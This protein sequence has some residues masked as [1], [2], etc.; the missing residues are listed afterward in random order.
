MIALTILVC[1]CMLDTTVATWTDPF[2][3]VTEPWVLD[4]PSVAGVTVSRT[5]GVLNMQRNSALDMTMDTLRHYAPAV[6]IKST[7]THTHTAGVTCLRVL[8][9]C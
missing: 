1:V 2:T 4:A 6:Y 3:S 5:S 9:Y 7:H 8:R